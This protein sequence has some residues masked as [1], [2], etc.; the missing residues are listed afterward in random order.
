MITL[1]NSQS[2]IGIDYPESGPAPVMPV[3]REPG[4]DSGSFAASAPSLSNELEASRSREPGRGGVAD[5][6]MNMAAMPGT[7]CSGVWV[8]HV[9]WFWE[10]E[11]P[12]G[13]NLAG[14][15]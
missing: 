2:V 14:I 12:V 4:S 15:V 8:E 9:V 7:P 13:G 5:M 6:P 11:P 10:D 3:P 1:S